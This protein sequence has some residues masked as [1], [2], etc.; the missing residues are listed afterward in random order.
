MFGTKK[1]KPAPAEAAAADGNATDAKS[2]DSE[3]PGA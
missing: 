2:A 1:K 3:E